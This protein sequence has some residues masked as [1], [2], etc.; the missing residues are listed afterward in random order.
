MEFAV[1]GAGGLIG[2]HLRK[3]L[4]GEGHVVRAL[5]RDGGSVDG[6]DVVIHLAG[7]PVAQRWTAEVKRRIRDSRVLGTERLLARIEAASRRPR[8]LVSAAAVGYYG[9]RGEE[10]L[11]ESSAPGTGFLA[12]SCVEWEQASA[13]GS[14]LGLRVVRMRMGMVLAANGGALQKMLPPFRMCVGG[15]ISDGRH[16]MSWIHIRDLA[17]L[18]FFC[19]TNDSMSGAV[20]AVAPESQRNTA[21][22]SALARALHRPAVIKVPKF[23]LHLLYGEMAQIVYCSQRVLPAAAEAAGFKFEYSTLV[24]ALDE[25]RL[26]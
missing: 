6:A 23:A 1:T 24:S 8:V 4:E 16:W 22:T 19:A 13:R 21:F 3:F 17:R 26:R 11:T 2:T 25:L 15:P 12:E 20:N 10:E 9:D 7:E 5:P 18:M 14:E